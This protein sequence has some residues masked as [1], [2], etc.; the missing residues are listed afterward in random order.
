MRCRACRRPL[1][2]PSSVR[3]GFGPQCLKRAVEQGQAPP[4]ALAELAA[5]R[6][7]KAIKKPP[8]SAPVKAGQQ[9]GD[10]FDF[11]D[12]TIDHNRQARISNP[13]ERTAM[14]DHD[15]NHPYARQ[16]IGCGHGVLYSEP[17]VDCEAVGLMN[18]YR[19]AVKTVQRVRDRM[20]QLGR[21]L[22]EI[23]AETA[24]RQADH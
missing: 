21:P 3:H 24:L 10:L 2:D 6:K 19:R 4:E 22:P 18:E 1:S 17:C 5:S 16:F 14:R 13:T 15:P 11:L 8:R 9:T 12:A 23:A 7:T 20:R